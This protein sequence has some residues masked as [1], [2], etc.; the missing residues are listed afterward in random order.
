MIELPSQAELRMLV[1]YEPHTGKLTWLAR[2]VPGWDKRWAGKPAFNIPSNGYLVGVLHGRRSIG[3]HRVAYKYMHGVDALEVDHI[4]GDR[5]D[6]R[7]TNLR[8]VTTTE[9]RRN[10]AMPRTN[11]SGIVGVH[12]RADRNKWVA[13]ISL[14]N[15]YTFLG[16]FATKEEAS[17]R[18]KAAEC[19]HGFHPNHGRIACR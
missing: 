5:A 19:E 9:N 13:Y 16:Y 8:E 12:W 11:R 7:I 2:G 17:A 10:A 18:R 6:N 15:R 4:N 3:A 1:H 14:A